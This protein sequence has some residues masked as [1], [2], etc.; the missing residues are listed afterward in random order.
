MYYYNFETEKETEVT[1]IRVDKKLFDLAKKYGE[2]NSDFS[3]SKLANKALFDFFCDDSFINDRIAYLKRML[4]NE[5]QLKLNFGNHTTKNCRFSEKMLQNFME[6]IEK[7]EKYFF[8]ET[9][10]VLEE[11][12]HD[13]LPGRYN[14]YRN[15]IDS[16]MSKN[17]FMIRLN[18][19]HEVTSNGTKN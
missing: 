12:G 15:T 13:Y 5:E 3:M 14:L 7:R 11:K 10:K 8:D 2:A 16:K 17:E 9:I 4:K 6:N 1:S 19:Y 18:M